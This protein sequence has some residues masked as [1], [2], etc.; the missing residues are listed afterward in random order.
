MLKDHTNIKRIKVTP[1]KREDGSGEEEADNFKR[2]I[3]FFTNN[4]TQDQDKWDK[5]SKRAGQCDSSYMFE[6]MLKL[7]EDKDK[8]KKMP[9]RKFFNNT[10]GQVLNNAMF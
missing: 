6:N 9:V 10:F 2:E 4:K 7:V 3:D 5:F 8:R 1:F